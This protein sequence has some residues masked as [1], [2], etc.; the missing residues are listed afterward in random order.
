MLRV[1]YELKNGISLRSAIVPVELGSVIKLPVEFNNVFS[2]NDG[3][4]RVLFVRVSVV[5]RPI[6]VSV[7]VGNVNVPVLV[8]VDITGAAENIFTAVIVCAVSRVTYELTDG[9]SLNRANCTDADGTV[10]VNS[11]FDIRE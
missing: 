10:N 8:I 2:P 11:E 9:I 7:L 4:F 3:L 1:T 5:A 6:R